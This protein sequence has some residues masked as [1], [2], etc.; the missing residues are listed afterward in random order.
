M[1]A[2]KIK[3]FKIA[4]AVSAIIIAGAIISIQMFSG[5]QPGEDLTPAAD[6]KPATTSA[7][8]FDSKAKKGVTRYTTDRGTE[9]VNDN[10]IVVERSGGGVLAPGGGN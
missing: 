3:K 2:D 7:A 9:M 10:G 1:D 5:P 8:T 6:R 4:G